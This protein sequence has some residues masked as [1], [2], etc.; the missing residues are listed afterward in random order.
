MS[1]TPARRSAGLTTTVLGVAAAALLLSGCS[2][3]APQ[4]GPSPTV[5]PTVHVTAATATAAS[6]SPT[7]IATAADQS[8]AP[9]ASSEPTMDPATSDP[10]TAAASASPTGVGP[11]AWHTDASGVITPDPNYTGQVAGTGPQ[12]PQLQDYETAAMAFATAWADPSVG[13][14]A[15]LARLRPMVTDEVY[16]GLTASDIRNVPAAVPT[17]AGNIEK[18]TPVNVSKRFAW[19]RFNGGGEI[20]LAMLAQPDGSWRITTFGPRR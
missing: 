20:G 5:R 1:S 4:A 2:P 6:P 17:N 19:V 16:Q 11:S 18:N 15:W 13:K 10:A 8:A 14:A 3:A 12:A 9:V 7:D